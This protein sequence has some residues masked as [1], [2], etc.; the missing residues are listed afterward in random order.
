M[1]R[2]ARRSRGGLLNPARQTS[3]ADGP[4]SP[5]LLLLRAQA[6]RTCML[7]SK[8]ALCGSTAR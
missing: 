5:P 3:P 1:P 8:W 6:G 2:Q 7:P 4:D